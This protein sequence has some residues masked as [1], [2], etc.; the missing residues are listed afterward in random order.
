MECYIHKQNARGSNISV[1]I[2]SMVS[3]REDLLIAHKP[4]CE[5]HGPQ[6]TE[7]PNEK[8]Q[9]MKFTQ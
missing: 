1:H 9:L 6:C 2:V 3:I 8:D 5:T 4:L 7:L